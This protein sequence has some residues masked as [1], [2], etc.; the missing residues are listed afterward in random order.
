MSG[1]GAEAAGLARSAVAAGSIADDGAAPLGGR[2][3]EERPQEPRN[4][5]V[6]RVITGSG[7]P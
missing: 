7:Q 3:G 4:G 2:S 5:A 1:S 6:S